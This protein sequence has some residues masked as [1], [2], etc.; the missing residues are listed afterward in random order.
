MKIIQ[1]RGFTLIEVVLSLVIMSIVMMI[2]APKF[3]NIQHDARVAQLHG[4][5][6][7]L[8]TTIQMVN[9]KA[10]I[11]LNPIVNASV[12]FK[13]KY[14]GY[15]LVKNEKIYVT[16]KDIT[17]SYNPVFNVGFAGKGANQKIASLMSVL[18]NID[19]NPIEKSKIMSN[20]L[21]VS[22]N[23]SDGIDIYSSKGFDMNCVI[24]YE[25]NKIKP[26]TIETS[27]C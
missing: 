22:E 12:N 18:I 10:E 24:H 25:A 14:A 23:G 8:I 21:F 26:I 1:Y 15:I 19:I 9:A 2:I 11:N 27:G 6:A 13:K 3:L 16:N 5:E 20:S 4:V 7:T 17:Q